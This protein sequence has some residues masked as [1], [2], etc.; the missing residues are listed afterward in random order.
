[1]L[2]SGCRQIEHSHTITY[3]QTCPLIV[4]SSYLSPRLYFIMTTTDYSF[5]AIPAV[6]IISLYP[7]L[8]A[9]RNPSRPPYNIC[10]LTHPKSKELKK[11]DRSLLNNHNPRST[12]LKPLQQQSM[13]AECYARYERAEASHKNGMENAPFFV[14][15]VV[16]GNIARL[17]ARMCC[18]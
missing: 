4:T 14:G 15:A 10:R 18:L 2:P 12:T 16:A 17:G 3:F 13:P 7:H 5:Y 9:V 11:V 1:M 8:Y 6:W